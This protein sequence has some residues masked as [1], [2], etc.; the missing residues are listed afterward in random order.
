[1]NK[2]KGISIAMDKGKDFSIAMDKAKGISI[3]IAKATDVSNSVLGCVF[4]GIYFSCDIPKAKS[5]CHN[6]NPIRNGIFRHILKNRPQIRRG[7]GI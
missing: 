4:F 3:A 6:P 2:A 1:M 7:N 5:Q